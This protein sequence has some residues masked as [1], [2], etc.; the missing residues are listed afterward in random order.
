VSIKYKWKDNKNKP[1]AQCWQKFR[2]SKTVSVLEHVS[3]KYK[4]KDNKQ[5]VCPVLAEVSVLGS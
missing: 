3:I 1:Y 4:W 2:I 5:T